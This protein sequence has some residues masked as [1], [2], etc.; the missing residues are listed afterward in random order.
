MTTTVVYPDEPGGSPS[1]DA[2]PQDIEVDKS[3][4]HASGSEARP[5]PNQACPAAML[6]YPRKGHTERWT[7]GVG[8]GGGGTLGLV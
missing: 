3:R 1:P 4:R 6:L 7:H 5:T 2:R 8:E